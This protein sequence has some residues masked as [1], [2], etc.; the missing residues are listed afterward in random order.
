MKECYPPFQLNK[1][2]IVINNILTALVYLLKRV[3]YNRNIIF[4]MTNVPSPNLFKGML[5]TALATHFT[6]PACYPF[7]MS[8]KP[9]FLNQDVPLLYL[10]FGYTHGPCLALYLVIL[11]ATEKLYVD[12]Y[13]SKSG[14]STF[15]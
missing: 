4:V 7:F 14:L 9:P 15:F 3:Q 1:P 6:G 12:R 5:R 8:Q 2:F 13:I 10:W 11:L